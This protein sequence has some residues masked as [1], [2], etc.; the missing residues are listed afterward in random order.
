MCMRPAT[1]CLLSLVASTCAPTARVA[2]QA[3]ATSEPAPAAAADDLGP[4]PAVRD[5]YRQVVALGVTEF[6]AGHWAEARAAFLRG[7]ELWPSARTLR[8]LGMTSFELRAYAR[9]ANELQAALDDVRRPLSAE[10]RAH[11]E[12]LLSQTRAFVGRY[13]VRLSPAAAQLLVDGAPAPP[14]RDAEAASRV[15]LLEVGRHELLAR[16]AGHESLRRTLDVQG[17]EDQELLLELQPT[18]SAHDAAAPASEALQATPEAPRPAQGASAAARATQVRETGGRLWTW[19]AGG[20]AVA[21]GVA[22]TA[23]WLHARSEFDALDAACARMPCVR[24]EVDES[25]FET[26]ETL[27]HVTLALAVG[28]GAGAV[29]L[30]FVEGGGD[31]G[32]RRPDA[33]LAIGPGAVALSGAF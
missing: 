19:V 29:L 2:A 30:Y 20:G 3:T 33:R 15:L 4:A 12:S 16:A 32:E 9:A 10:Q 24:G 28:A 14:A 18:T 27:H 11:V 6:A 22:S 8:S 5:E 7:H 13:R 26:P 21:L 17:R 23:L 31:S 1:V 25:R